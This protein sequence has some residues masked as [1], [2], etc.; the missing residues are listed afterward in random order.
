MA[1]LGHLIIIPDYIGFGAS[2]PLQHPYHN[3]VLF[4][5]T[6]YDLIIAVMDMEESNDYD[7]TL[8]GDLFLTG[9]SLGGWASLIAHNYLEN[10][11]IEGLNFIGSACG[12]GAYNLLWMRDYLV[13]QINYIQPFYIPNMLMGYMSTGELTYEIST[14]I[15]EPYASKIPYLIDEEHSSGQINAEL[16]HNMQELFTEGFLFDFYSDTD[17]VWIDMQDLLRDNSQSAWLNNKP[18]S[19]YHGNMDIHVPYLISEKLVNDFRQL[20]VNENMLEFI[21]LPGLDHGTGVMPMYLDVINKL[22]DRQR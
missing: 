14:Y 8:N 5:R 19:L 7:F 22:L 16:T 17:L 9:Y 3:K 12:A 2:E 11:P 6:I 1:G 13:E 10:H 4:Q 15:N 20:G 21:T 18:I